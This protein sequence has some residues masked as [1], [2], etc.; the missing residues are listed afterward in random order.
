ME[1]ILKINLWDD[2]QRQVRIADIDALQI[3]GGKPINYD[4]AIA[5]VVQSL[6]KQ[7]ANPNMKIPV[8]ISFDPPLDANSQRLL[9]TVKRVDSPASP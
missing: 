1:G 4:W 6:Q 8:R 9:K 2:A 7:S 5:A 3:V